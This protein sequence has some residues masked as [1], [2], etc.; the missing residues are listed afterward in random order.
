[1]IPIIHHLPGLP[2]LILAACVWLAVVIYLRARALI[3]WAHM[4]T[5]WDQEQED[6]EMCQRCTD[7]DCGATCFARQLA[8]P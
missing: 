1:M 6:R 7:Y 3:R 4:L 2:W 8:E 5:E